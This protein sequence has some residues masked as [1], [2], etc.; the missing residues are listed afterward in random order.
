[1]SWRCRSGSSRRGDPDRVY[2]PCESKRKAISL[3]LYKHGT[4][5]WAKKVHH[6]TWALSSPQHGHK[7][8][9]EESRIPFAFPEPPSGGVLLEDCDLVIRIEGEI[10][11]LFAL[12]REHGHCYFL[13][14]SGPCTC[15]QEMMIIIPSGDDDETLG[16]IGVKNK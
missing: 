2:S 1:M 14:T 3:F 8:L 6:R 15:T 9:W 10:R 7:I 13:W 12:V 4:P 11:G 16:C 5:D